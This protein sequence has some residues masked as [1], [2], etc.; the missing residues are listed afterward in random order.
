MEQPNGFAQL[1][2]ERQAD[3]RFAGRR[4]TVEANLSRE[5]C[6]WIISDEGAGFDWQTMP[7]EIGP[8]A[9]FAFNGRGIIITRFQ[10]DEMEYLGNGSKVRLKKLIQPPA[11]SQS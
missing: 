6:E 8:E 3:P 4:V 1:I 11:S 2:A 10:F 5:A 9:L 7:D